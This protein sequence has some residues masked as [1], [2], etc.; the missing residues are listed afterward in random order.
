MTKA[1]LCNTRNSATEYNEGETGRDQQGR[2]GRGRPPRGGSAP[3]AGGTAASLPTWIAECV[4]PEA[5]A[6]PPLDAGEWCCRG[7]GAVF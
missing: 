6:P 4:G 1:L 5:A 2:P 3:G 7:H